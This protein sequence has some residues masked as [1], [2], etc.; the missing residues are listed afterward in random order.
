MLLARPLADKSARNGVQSR[1]EQEGQRVMRVTICERRVQGRALC[2]RS[3]A[4]LGAWLLWV[5]AAANAQDVA[6]EQ[7]AATDTADP[8]AAALAPNTATSVNAGAPEQ[9]QPPVTAPP[10]YYTTPPPT[11]TA[12]PPTAPPQE[13]KPDQPPP[14]TTQVLPSQAQAAVT[15]TPALR[16]SVDHD[17]GRADE[18]LT[19]TVQS[20]S[21]NA[22]LPRGIQVL[23]MRDG[24]VFRRVRVGTDGQARAGL[25]AGRYTARAQASAAPIGT[26]YQSR[27][28]SNDVRVDVIDQP[29]SAPKQQPAVAPASP[30]TDAPKLPAPPPASD[31]PS[32]RLDTRPSEPSAPPWT[33]LLAIALSLLALSGGGL[34]LRARIRK[35]SA[36]SAPRL[37]ANVHVSHALEFRSPPRIRFRLTARAVPDRGRQRILPPSTPAPKLEDDHGRSADHP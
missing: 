23:I 14:P 33:A 10:L 8:N 7:P 15:E 3:N 34:A 9:A 18:P 17:L 35:R 4:W 25:P 21:P 27:L 28:S 24:A 11:T 36:I 31:N 13:V 5:A 12:Q 26:A 2:W 22:R 19:F 6:P 20:N 37:T 16:L 1:A 30:A 29:P 32:A